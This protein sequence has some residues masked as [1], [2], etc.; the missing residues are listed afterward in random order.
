MDFDIVLVIALVVAVVVFLQL[1]SVLGKR[2][3]FERP[4]FDP[5]SRE[6]NKLGEKEEK[7]DVDKVVALP[8]QEVKA[9]DDFSDIDVLAPKDSDLNKG[10]RTI[11]KQDPTF[12][13]QSFLDG[14]R[15]AYEMVV[16]AFAKGDKKT[17]KS[18][19][20]D[21]VYGGFSHAIDER[22]N[23]GDTINF[24]FV[25]IDKIEL[26][27]AQMQN[28]DAQLT[29]RIESEIISATYDDDQKL[30]DGDPQAIAEIKDIW[31]FSRD[32]KSRDPNWKIIGTEDGN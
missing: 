6:T 8:K 21:D 11:R 16:T 7:E 1:R 2:T 13:P 14:A 10:L 26:V 28:H 20:S 31:T 18:L 27:D 12:S 22:N 24:T 25:G 3:G 17:L 30:I 4:P 23:K 15:V 29:I 19:L 9:A 32:V 5:Y